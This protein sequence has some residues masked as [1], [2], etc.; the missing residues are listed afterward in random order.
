LKLSSLFDRA[1]GLRCGE[2]LALQLSDVDLDGT[3]V[4]VAR[5]V[6]ETKAGL[7]WP[8]FVSIGASSLSWGWL[9]GAGRPD[10]DAPAIPDQPR[11]RANSAQ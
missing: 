1:T 4:Q 6:Q 11:E 9:L 3:T 2:L 10:E 5:S 8:Y 7:R